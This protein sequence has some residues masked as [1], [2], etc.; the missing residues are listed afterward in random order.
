MIRLQNL[1]M[2][3]QESDDTVLE[4]GDLVTDSNDKGS[5]I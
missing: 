4:S 2:K 3:G 5:R 1:M